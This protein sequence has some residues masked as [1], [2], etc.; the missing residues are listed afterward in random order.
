MWL[1]ITLCINFHRQRLSKL[2][3]DFP[4]EGEA[5]AMAARPKGRAW[6]G[7]VAPGFIGLL[8]V[9]MVAVA[10]PEIT[11]IDT[12]GNSNEAPKAH[13]NA[14]GAADQAP[15]PGYDLTWST[16]GTTLQT[17]DFWLP[18]NRKM[19]SMSLGP[20]MNAFDVFVEP[21]GRLRIKEEVL[22]WMYDRN[23]FAGGVTRLLVD[24][25][26]NG[27]FLDV[28]P[29]DEVVLEFYAEF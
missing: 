19:H 23:R 17:T 12:V 11:A 3:E 6:T 7:R 1:A 16:S 10:D 2:Q 15:L 28:D 22:G 24:K 29:G 5:G 14:F 21:P 4:S 26:D 27:F 20:R 18:R 25:P 13:F 9:N 8:L